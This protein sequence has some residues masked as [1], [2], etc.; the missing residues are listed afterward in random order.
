M[1]VVLI[2]GSPRP[3]GNTSDV[4]KVCC[5]ASEAEGLEVKVIDLAG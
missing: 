5:E 4:I 1:K 2:N 3:H